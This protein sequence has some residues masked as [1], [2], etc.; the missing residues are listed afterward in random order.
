MREK[1]SG[2][3]GSSKEET[4]MFGRRVIHVAEFEFHPSIVRFGAA[5]CMHHIQ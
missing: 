1:G 3:G 4:N 2:R 5:R